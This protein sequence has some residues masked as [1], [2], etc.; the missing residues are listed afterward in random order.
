M[1]GFCILTDST[2]QFIT[3]FCPGQALV[4]ITPLQ[5][6][7]E[8]QVYPHGQG[9]GIT[10]LPASAVNGNYPNLSPPTIEHFHNIYLSLSTKYSKI[11]TI[12]HAVAL[13]K[14]FTHAQ[15][16]LLSFADQDSHP[17]I[18]SQTTGI[19][20]GWL[21]EAAVDAAL[22]GSPITVIRRLVCDLARK[23]YTLFC[24]QSLTY[25]YRSGYLNPAQA[26]VGDMLSLTPIF[27]IERG[28]LVLVQKTRGCVTW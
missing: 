9:L 19:G 12:V 14:T 1:P 28:N 2:E 17:L 20:L 24:T 11:P 4:R 26:I 6:K 5:V 25:L 3:S 15:L 10:D 8:N 18:D 16:A 22:N 13:S 27:S 7:L 21:V 23:I